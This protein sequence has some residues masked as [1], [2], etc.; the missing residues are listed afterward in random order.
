MCRAL[1]QPTGVRCS[2][3]FPEMMLLFLLTFTHCLKAVESRLLPTQSDKLE[4][5]AWKVAAVSSQILKIIILI[6]I[7]LFWCYLQCMTSW[8]GFPAYP[9]LMLVSYLTFHLKCP[10]K[11]LVI[12]C[13][14]SHLFQVK[15][16][17]LGILFCCLFVCL[18]A[19]HT[20]KQVYF[21]HIHSM[22]TWY[23]TRRNWSNL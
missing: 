1:S 18:G 10:L 14:I 17:F 21:L 20:L 7:F 19:L 9:K 13:S 15:E 22:T 23:E 5:K 4:F 6:T 11:L 12:F 8:Q 2:G 16:A 3:F